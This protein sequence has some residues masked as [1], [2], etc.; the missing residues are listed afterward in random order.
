MVFYLS[1]VFYLSI[2]HIP[3][4]VCVCS[5]PFFFK[6]DT[7]GIQRNMFPG[8]TCVLHTLWNDRMP[9]M[10]QCVLNK[11]KHDPDFI[12]PHCVT[13][14]FTLC[15]TVC[16]TQRH[17]RDSIWRHGGL[18]EHVCPFFPFDLRD[19]LHVGHEV[20]NDMISRYQVS[21]PWSKPNRS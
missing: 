9:K 21:I 3:L 13:P 5:R 20:S 16:K 8:K 11:Y 12:W 18:C 17:C 10:V 1:V 19:D 2:P 7:P 6:R 14:F 4:T 15:R